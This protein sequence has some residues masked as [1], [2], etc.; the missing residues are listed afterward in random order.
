[1]TVAVLLR[2]V[3]PETDL[4]V[5]EQ[6]FEARQALKRAC[7]HDLHGFWPSA[8][9]AWVEPIRRS[10]V[11]RLDEAC[12]R[13][14]PGARGARLTGGDDAPG[15]GDIWE[16]GSSIPWHNDPAK[17]RAFALLWY[18]GD[19]EGGELQVAREPESAK[20]PRSFVT[21]AVRR[22]SMVAFRESHLHQ[23]LPVRS[24][25]RFALFWDAFAD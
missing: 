6:A 19:F 12:E 14:F 20:P 11:G 15:T 10:V 23:V 18:C 25:T 16:G 7:G 2:N 22:N 3:V 1:M 13:L 21:C 24:G 4:L 8:G 9:E 17:P 5:A